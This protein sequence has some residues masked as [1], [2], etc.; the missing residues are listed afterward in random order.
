MKVAAII[1]ARMTSTRLPGKI[2]RP[3]MGRPMLELMIERLERCSNVDSIIVATTSNDTDNPVEALSRRLGVGCYRG[4]E[5]DVLLRVVEAAEAHGVDVIVEVT[6]DC[7]LIDP[8]IV[9]RVADVY[10][11][12]EYDYVSNILERTYPIGM[13]VQVFA[14]RDLR[15]VEQKTDDP[16]DR[17]HVSLYFYEVPGRFRTRNVASDL[18]EQHREHRL[19]V[20]TIEDFTLIEEIFKKLYPKTPAF[21]L[22]DILRL[23]E[24]YPE[25]AGINKGVQQKSVR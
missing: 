19:T 21:S 5:D 6:G 18:P 15:Q 4:S 22:D 17:E 3:I 10:L 14:T 23:L 2:L 24:E 9:D 11:D 16:A 20:D 1:E 8:S 13:D 25:L 12:G 7:P